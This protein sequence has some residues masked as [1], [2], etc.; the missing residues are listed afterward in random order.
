MKKILIDIKVNTESLAR[1]QQIPDA[2]VTT[3]E[4][5]E[6]FRLLPKEIIHDQNILFCTCPPTNFSDMKNVELIQIA[7]ASYTQLFDLGLVERNVRACNAA[8]VNDIPIAEWNIAMMINLAR[9]L[10][11]MIRNQE[12]GKWDRD[13]RFQREI[14]GSKAGIWGYGGIGRETARLAKNMGMVVHVLDAQKI[15]PRKN[16]YTVSGSGD[17]E[18][19]LPDRAFTLGQEKGFLSELDFLILS[20]PLTKRTEGIVTEQYLKMLPPHAFVL[21]PARG[22]LI[23][24]QALLKALTENWIAGA[25]LDTHYHYP[26]PAAHPLWQFPNVIMTPHISGS[27]LS[28]CFLERIW[29]VFLQNVERYAKG[30][31]LLNELT[32][33]QLLGQ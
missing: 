18:G 12:C 8:G 22:P 31:T 23:N 3:V 29:D 21:N 32:S 6:D 30:Q 24:E 15:G 4:P 19:V 26:M 16:Y 11:G 20:M 9:D 13:A 5:S 10:R 7:S 14:R 33:A 17:I 1:L 2:C 28:P 25:A 27:S